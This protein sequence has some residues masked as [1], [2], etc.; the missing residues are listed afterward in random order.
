MAHLVG[1]LV[2]KGNG[3]NFIGGLSFVQKVDYPSRD[4][5][6]FPGPGAGQNQDRALG[7]PDRFELLWVQIKKARH[8]E[9]NGELSGERVRTQGKR[10]GMM[11]CRR[12]GKCKVRSWERWNARQTRL[13]RTP[14]AKRSQPALSAELYRSA[15]KSQLITFQN[16]FTYSARRF[17]YLR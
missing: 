4:D 14:N 15:A 9:W 13:R 5:A 7:C 10:Q 8:T 2:C 11:A 1:G 17:W 12:I 3:E 6:G 16:A